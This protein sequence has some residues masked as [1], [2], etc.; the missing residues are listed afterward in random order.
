VTNCQ[1]GALG[2]SHASR[3]KRRGAPVRKNEWSVKNRTANALKVDAVLQDGE[4]KVGTT[5][6]RGEKGKEE[7]EH[8]KLGKNGRERIRN[9]N[10]T[11]RTL[12]RKKME[13]AAKWV[14]STRGA[15]M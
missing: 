14:F 1:E 7:K 3:K 13:N 4:R 6:G 2:K 5:V 10:K 11:S 8:A 15:A 12:Q 9:D